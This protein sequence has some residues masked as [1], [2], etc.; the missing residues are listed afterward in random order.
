MGTGPKT[1]PFRNGYNCR[2]LVWNHLTP[3]LA[4]WHR[5]V[6]FGHIGTGESDSTAYDPQK[7]EVRHG[8]AQNVVGIYQELDLREVTLVAHS[9]G[10]II[11]GCQ[12][13]DPVNGLHYKR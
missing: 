10:C 12:V 3:A 8:Y 11:I 9:E 2:Q 4:M 5:L 7:Y 1:L 6:F 13:T